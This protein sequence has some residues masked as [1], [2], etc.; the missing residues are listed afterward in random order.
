MTR[1][2]V[3]QG[4]FAGLTGELLGVEAGLARVRLLVFGRE[5]EVDLPSRFVTAEAE[6]RDAILTAL[7]ARISRELAAWHEEEAQ[8]FWWD[9]VEDVEVEP[10]AEHQAWVQHQAQVALRAAEQLRELLVRFE[11]EIVPS[12]DPRA[13]VEAEP[14]RWTPDTVRQER[15]KAEWRQHEALFLQHRARSEAAWARRSRAEQAAEDA[16]YVAWRD[17]VASPAARRESSEA[18]VAQAERCWSGFVE[19]VERVWGFRLP[20]M[21]R[22]FLVFWDGR[23]EEERAT[24]A[25]LGVQPGGLGRRWLGWCAAPGALCADPDEAGGLE[26]YRRDPPEFVLFL[27]GGDDGL[28]WGLWFDEPERCV[29]VCSYY[30]N[31]G[32]DLGPPAGTPLLALKAR[33][34]AHLDQLDAP[35]SLRAPRLPE[36]HLQLQ[37]FR[38][39]LLL[40]SV[41]E[42]LTVEDQEARDPRPRLGTLDGAGAL[43]TGRTVEARQGGRHAGFWDEVGGYLDTLHGDGVVAR[44]EEAIR[45]CEAGDPAE[46]LVLGRDLWWVGETPARR[47]LAA[48]LL[49]RAYRA[50]GREALAR[51]VEQISGT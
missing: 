43:V 40:E 41:G 42:A 48:A 30:H 11:A 33:L 24:L 39:R 34:Q 38:M 9:R 19:A 50:L 49:V 25:Q 22:R 3:E 32:V 15:L 36:E 5:A 21:Y 27:H 10:L 16:A 51:R 8:G 35:A 44:V 26:R 7:R 46:A 4:A 28:H 2:H 14:D 1:V 23:S 29:G 18:A 6:D 31:D 12:D 47:E 13:R 17:G 45:R 20:E 37:K